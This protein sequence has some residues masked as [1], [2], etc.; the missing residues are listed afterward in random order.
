MPITEWEEQF[1][2]EDGSACETDPS[3]WNAVCEPCDEQLYKDVIKSFET[4]LATL[5]I[6][7]DLSDV[8]ITPLHFLLHRYLQGESASE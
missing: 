2:I 8:T 3:S 4:V 5:G 7:A 6:E 1:K